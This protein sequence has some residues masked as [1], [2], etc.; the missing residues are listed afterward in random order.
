MKP[1]I[2]FTDGA[3]RGNPGPGGWGAVI[4]FDDKVI[5][6]GGKE[7]HTTNNR[8]EI[9]AALNALLHMKNLPEEITVLTDSSYLI[10]GITK[11]VKDWVK[12]GWTTKAKEDVQNRDL[13]ELLAAE[14]A[15]RSNEDG[16]K[17]VL[18]KRVSGHAQVPGNE[19]ADQIATRYADTPEEKLGDIDLGLYNGSAKDYKFDLSIS[20]ADAG[21]KEKRDKSR[22]RAGAYSYLSKVDGKIEIHK[23]WAECEKRVKGVSGA[24]FK[25]ALSSIE[26]KAI[27]GEWSS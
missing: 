19:R 14:L 27:I 11:W 23:T 3:S 18:W 25:K 4:S 26:E 6:L 24:K 5:E 15:E 7:E 12:N 2:I 8:M 20:K 21:A 10:N 22:S 1:V 17:D 16:F 9:T 13:W